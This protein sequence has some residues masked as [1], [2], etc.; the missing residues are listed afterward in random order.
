L[1]RP[2]IQSVIL[3]WSTMERTKSGLKMHPFSAL[4]IFAV[5]IHPDSRGWVRLKSPD[6]AAAPAIR[7]NFL[8]TEQDRRTIVAGIKFSRQIAAA[9][10][11]ASHV[12]EEFQPGAAVASDAQLLDYCRDR[13]ISLYHPVGTCRMGHDPLAV[14]DPRLRVHGVEG[15]R[16]IDASVMP[17]IISGNTNAPTIMIGEKGAEMILQDARVH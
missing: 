6:P 2:D 13:A 16:V 1:D 14:V 7:F 11:L 4:S 3:P 15:L 10:P 5:H 17:E 12:S 8:E 9:M